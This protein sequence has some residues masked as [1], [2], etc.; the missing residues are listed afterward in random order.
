MSSGL[1]LSSVLL[2]GATEKI[3][4]ALKAKLREKLDSCNGS[5]ELEHIHK[6]V[7]LAQRF[8]GVPAAW[9]EQ[10]A[11]KTTSA[12]EQEA[13]RALQEAIQQATEVLDKVP[14]AM[15]ALQDYTPF[16]SSMPAIVKKEVG[17]LL[18]L[19]VKFLEHVVC[20]PICIS[21]PGDSKREHASA[22]LSALEAVGLQIA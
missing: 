12:K 22:V 9:V 13:Q 6:L 10:A 11:A 21:E 17:V 7:G 19:A 14:E 8:C 4:A 5:A 16:A 3:E 15:Q 2:P 1:F 20:E 18:V